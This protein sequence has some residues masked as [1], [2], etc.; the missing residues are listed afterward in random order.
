[1]KRLCL[2]LCLILF[3][4]LGAGPVAAASATVP[5]DQMIKDTTNKVIKELTENRDELKNNS[6]KLYKMVNDVVLPHFDFQRMSRYVLGRYWRQAT[7]DQQKKFVEQFKTLLVRTYA[8]A[9]FQYTGQKITYKPFHHDEGDSRA[10]VKTEIDRSDGPPIP[11]DY[12][13]SL[14]NGEWK[15]YDIKIDN[16]SL[17]TNYRSQYGEIIQTQG[18]DKLIAELTKKNEELLKQ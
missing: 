17:V 3:P 14:D 1:M 13:L 9:L 7:P 15:V 6:Q 16:L 10:V 12:T 11:I 8:T 5:P 2:C 4:V 18:M